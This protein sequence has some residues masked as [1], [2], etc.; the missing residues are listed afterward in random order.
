M[1]VNHDEESEKYCI[2]GRS[3]DTIVELSYIA[4]IN[5][6]IAETATRK[7]VWAGARV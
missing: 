6:E 7:R 2:Y 3:R 1:E 4:Q 5:I